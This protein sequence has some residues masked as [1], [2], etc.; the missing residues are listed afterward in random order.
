MKV[1]CGIIDC[2]GINSQQSSKIKGV[3]VLHW[4]QRG[5]NGSECQ[6]ND[7]LQT[8]LSKIS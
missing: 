6:G 7:L 2:N 4:E 1:Q 5:L 8:Q 3:S